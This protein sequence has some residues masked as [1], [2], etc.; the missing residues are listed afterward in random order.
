MIILHFLSCFSWENLLKDCCN[1]PLLMILFTPTTFQ[2][3]MQATQQKQFFLI[4]QRPS[5]GHYLSCASV[6]V[7]IFMGVGH[8][9]FK[10]SI[11][12]ENKSL[13]IFNITKMATITQLLERPMK[14]LKLFSG[15]IQNIQTENL[16]FQIRC[17][18]ILVCCC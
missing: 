11:L 1:L 13:G 18:C 3:L 17:R 16:N 5:I 10:S 8:L 14:F 6:V 15:V 2:T 12:A 7:F 4:D 9:L